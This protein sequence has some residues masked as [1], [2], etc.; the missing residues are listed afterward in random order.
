MKWD[1]P[2]R[3]DKHILAVLAL[4]MGACLLLPGLAPAHGPYGRVQAASSYSS[5]GYST[6][7]Q[8]KTYVLQ[9]YA[10]E[11]VVTE[12]LEVDPY[13]AQ[14]QAVILKKV[15]PVVAET[16]TKRVLVVKEVPAQ[17]QVNVK[18][19]AVVQNVEV[20]KVVQQKVVQQNVKVKNVAVKNVQVQNVKVKNVQVNAKVNA[21]ANAKVQN[22]KANAKAA[23][24]NAKAA[25]ANARAARANARA[26][27]RGH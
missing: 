14:R 8:T 2:C 3:A 27:K 10:V 17:V 4:V 21:K 9:D 5:S 19:R 6:R 16:V 25:R 18:K 1:F 22:A 12:V 7:V 26:A 24:A 11:P 15:T 13:A 20:K 23:R